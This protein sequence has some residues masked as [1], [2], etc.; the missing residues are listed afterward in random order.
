[1]AL[2]PITEGMSGEQAAETILANDNYLLGLI[3][4][5]DDIVRR[6]LTLNSKN[7]F[8]KSKATD[9]VYANY[10][11]GALEPL[12]TFFTSDFIKV[13]PGL[14]YALSIGSSLSGDQM[15]FYDIN[16]NYVSGLASAYS[17]TVPGNAHYVRVN[18]ALTNKN[19]LMLA[20]GSTATAYEPY[21]EAEVIDPELVR[22]TVAINH[23]LMRTVTVAQDGGA[24][25][26][27]ITDA[28]NSTKGTAAKP[29]TIVIAGGVYEENLNTVGKY[30]S[31]IGVNK[32]DVVVLRQ[33]GN[34]YFPPL[35]CSGGSYFQNI[36]FK[37]TS[38]VPDPNRTILSYAVHMD[39]YGAG[40]AE[41]FNCIMES[42]QN[43]AMGIGLHQDQHLIINACELKKITTEGT[44]PN[45]GSLYFHNSPGAES[46]QKLTVKNS[47]I[48]TDLGVSL[49]IDDARA[50][51]GGVD[52]NTIVTFYNNMFYS[53]QYGKTPASWLM[54]NAPVDGGISGKIKLTPDS[55]GNNIALINA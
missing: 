33:D 11:T 50:N 21:S 29:Q 26:R 44:D 35:E 47:V 34:Y 8:D 7:L 10:Q 54:Y 48:T 17:F 55:Y 1:M 23:K 14:T 30:V 27:T 45:G 39:F 31:L 37:S 5:T 46:N 40:I 49:R 6:Y 4:P 18:A 9:F 52:I 19:T 22:N 13:E 25:F 32:R 42:H 20:L 24:D 43:A 38:D 28:I 16:K 41:F 51:A 12:G 2:Q 53:G 36:H 15:P 3:G